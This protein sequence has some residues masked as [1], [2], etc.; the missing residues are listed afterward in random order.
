MNKNVV[1][2]VCL[3]YLLHGYVF[4][5]VAFSTVQKWSERFDNAGI[6]WNAFF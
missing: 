2:L 3:I 4:T 1:W 6:T 5:F